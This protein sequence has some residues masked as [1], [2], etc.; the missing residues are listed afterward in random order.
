MLNGKTAIVTG[1][2]RG[3]GRAIAVKLA[4]LGAD[5]AVIYAGNDAAAE[6]AKTECEEKGVRCETFK[7]DV[8]DFAAVKETVA[9]V[10]AAFGTV[11][12]LVNSAGITRDGLL[13]MMKESDFDDVIA[14][15]LKGT[16]NMIKHCA[17]IFIRNKGGRI[18]NISS[19]SGIMGNGG[20]ANYSASKAGVIGLTKSAAREL[21]ARG[22]TCNAIAPGFIKTDMTAGFDDSN[23]LV[24]SIPLGRMGS[25]E[26]VAELAAFLA[27]DGAAYITGEVIR[28]DGGMAI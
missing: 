24:K 28:V 26:E 21:A 17:P 7:C 5:I 4:S 18:I 6:E 12:I 25:P 8:A 23:P 3:I 13:A 1:G 10:K 14:A 22:I 2:S 20:Q 27:G 19:V 16:F 9:A 15:N 11:N